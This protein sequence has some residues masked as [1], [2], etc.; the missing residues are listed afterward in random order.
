MSTYFIA[1]HRKYGR[2]FYAKSLEIASHLR[3]NKENTEEDAEMKKLIAVL[4]VIVC[5]A[6]C[7]GTIATAYASWH[8]E[9]TREVGFNYIPAGEEGF[10]TV[11]FINDTDFEDYSLLSQP[12]AS[13]SQ[14]GLA[15]YVL[16][17]ENMSVYDGDA[18]KPYYF[19]GWYTS[20]SGGERVENLASF[21][22][23]TQIV[24]YARWEE[25][26][27][28]DVTLNDIS[29]TNDIAFVLQTTSQ[30]SLQSSY[31]IVTQSY[32][33]SPESQWSITISAGSQSV[34]ITSATTTLAQGQRYSYAALTRMSI[35][36][37]PSELTAV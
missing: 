8:I 36:N 14:D 18:A 32:Y 25:K 1:L 7:A 29:Q 13:I 9:D 22:S 31:G 33:I 19:G 6:L 21:E 3:Y 35:I 37:L 4:S 12:Q 11:T 16:P 5:A 26:A 23:A 2:T 27:V 15:S 10:I 34:S 30:Y 20:Q 17:E 24:L 28:L